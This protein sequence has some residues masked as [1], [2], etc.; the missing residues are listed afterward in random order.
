MGRSLSEIIRDWALEAVN[1]QFLSLSIQLH[2]MRM[3]MALNADELKARMNE[4]TN[5]LG[6]DLRNLKDQLAAALESKE[7]YADERVQQS[8]SGFDSIADSLE[9]LAADTPEDPI[10]EVSE[11]PAGGGDDTVKAP[12]QLTPDAE[13]EAAEVGESTPVGGELTD[14][15]AD[16]AA[17]DEHGEVADETAR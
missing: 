2:E 9:A 4:A 1:E 17:T 15:D 11:A 3:Q 12:D 6:G 8:L 14:E 7:V 16:A 10:S 13:P 5:N